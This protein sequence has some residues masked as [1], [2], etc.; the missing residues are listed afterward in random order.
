MEKVKKWLL[1]IISGFK[2][3]LEWSDGYYEWFMGI[4]LDKWDT[5]LCASATSGLL[6]ASMD[7]KKRKK[8]RKRIEEIFI[9]KELL[10]KKCQ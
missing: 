1:K 6:F 3:R 5:K 2:S 7:G 10:E 8:I 9:H 4:P